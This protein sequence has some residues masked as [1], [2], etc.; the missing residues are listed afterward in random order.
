MLNTDMKQPFLTNVSMTMFLNIGLT[1]E[2][3]TKNITTMG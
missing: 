3:E 2:I 1:I